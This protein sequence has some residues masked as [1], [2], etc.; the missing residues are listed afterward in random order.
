MGKYKKAPKDRQCT[1]CNSTHTDNQRR[2]TVFNGW[3]YYPVWHIYKGKY[4]C[5]KC[6]HRKTYEDFIKVRDSPFS[7]TYEEVSK[8]D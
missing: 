4:V 8:W 5:H 6:Y 7:F 2:Y 1:S 3:K